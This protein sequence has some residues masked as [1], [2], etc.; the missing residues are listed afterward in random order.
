MNDQR[1]LI[2]LVIPLILVAATLIGVFI[3]WL[4]IVKNPLTP[5]VP[6]QQTAT[7][8]TTPQVSQSSQYQN[9]FE[10]SS[11]SSNPFD[12]QSQNPFDN[13]K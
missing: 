11:G 5:V 7:S 10:A 13:L 4:G 1:G 12:N 3:I 2:A 6:T 9:P 8:K